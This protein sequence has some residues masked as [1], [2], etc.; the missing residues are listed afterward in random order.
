MDDLTGLS[1]E[2]LSLMIKM[3]QGALSD[4]TKNDEKQAETRPNKF[5]DMPEFSMHK[6]DSI[7]DQKL[8]VRP[9]TPRTRQ[10][11]PVAVKCRVCGKEE[12][13]NPSLL[14]TEKSRYKC[15]KCSAIAG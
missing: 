7:I 10:F 1:N 3:L 2:Q 5:L 8:N 4:R 6:N 15:N 14:S 9:P 13:I 12:T 11:N